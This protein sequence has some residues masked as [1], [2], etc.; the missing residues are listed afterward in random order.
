MKKLSK[1]LASL[2]SVCL[3]AGTAAA[4]REDGVVKVDETKVQLL[5]GNFDGGYGSA[6]LNKAKDRFV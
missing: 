1:S 5:V 3:L 2:L 6:W 4:C